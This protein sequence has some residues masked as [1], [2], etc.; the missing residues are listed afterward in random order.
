MAATA[1]RAGA[2]SGPPSAP[3][4]HARTS[5]T[6]A[7]SEAP[8]AMARSTSSESTFVVPSQIGITCA[9]RSSLGNPVSST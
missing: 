5:V 3:L 6:T 9:S 7:S 1:L 8:W 2:S 4:V